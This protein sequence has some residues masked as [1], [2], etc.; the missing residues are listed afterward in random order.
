VQEA[1][2]LRKQL[3]DDIAAVAARFAGPE[4]QERRQM[5][6]KQLLEDLSTADPSARQGLIRRC[7]LAIILNPENDQA[8]ND[9]AWAMVSVPDDPW[10][11]PKQALALAR[12][13]VALN[14]THWYFWNTLGVAAYRVREWGTASEY[15]EKSIGINGGQANDCFFLAMTRWQQGKRK[16]ARQV[17]QQAVEWISRNKAENNTELRR[18]HVEA[19]ALLGLPGPGAKPG[20]TPGGTNGQT[21]ETV[22]KKSQKPEQ[23]S[24]ST[25]KAKTPDTF[26]SQCPDPKD[27]SPH[28]L[29]TPEGGNLSMDETSS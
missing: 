20:S 13:A 17:F 18:F 21:T 3:V 11:D 23:Q 16:E 12:K 2:S 4:F 24:H 5:W 15:L 14:P 1:E 9:L 19:A 7:R 22:N 25:G 26:G 28:L 8:L 27:R 29:S 10:F 6:S